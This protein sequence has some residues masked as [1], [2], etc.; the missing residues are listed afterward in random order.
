MRAAAWCSPW[1]RL[2]WRKTGGS[3]SAYG[4]ELRQTSIVT[5]RGRGDSDQ[6]T[7]RTG[8]ENGGEG[9]GGGGGASRRAN[10]RGRGCGRGITAGGGGAR[11]DLIW[12]RR[13]EK[14]GK[15]REWHRG[16]GESQPEAVATHAV[17]AH[18]PAPA[19]R[20]RRTL[21]VAAHTRRPGGACAPTSF[22]AMANELAVRL[23]ANATTFLPRRRRRGH[24]RHG[25]AASWPLDNG[26]RHEPRHPRPG[27]GEDAA[28]A[29]H[30]GLFCSP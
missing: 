26:R 1:A 7:T 30:D 17:V 14:G 19:G 11:L 5:S 2:E 20:R 24:P 22:N 8:R 12:D 3:S 27:R 9:G 16:G 21:P 28:G 15:G 13:R 23:G 29:W 6:E 10:R 4:S 25:L 18:P